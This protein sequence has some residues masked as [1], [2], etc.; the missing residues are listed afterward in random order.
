MSSQA[1]RRPRAVGPHTFRVETIAKMWSRP[2]GHECYVHKHGDAWVVTL[3]RNGQVLRESNVE[4]PGDALRMSA[5]FRVVA[6]A[7]TGDAR[8]A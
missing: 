3:E 6:R 8:S 1:F 2:D 5:E 7:S 4:S